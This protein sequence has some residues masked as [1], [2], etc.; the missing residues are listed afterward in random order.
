M[1]SRKE[2]LKFIKDHP[3]VGG[4]IAA[5][6]LLITGVMCTGT[7][8]ALELGIDVF[9][10][11]TG[12]ITPG[13]L[14]PGTAL[15]DQNPSDNEPKAKPGCKIVR[16]KETPVQLMARSGEQIYPGKQ[17]V[18]EYTAFGHGGGRDV[19]PAG[20]LDD[21]DR[22]SRVIWAG[23]QFCPRNPVQLNFDNKNATA[24]ESTNEGCI[25]VNADDTIWG[26]VFNNSAH[27]GIKD[28]IVVKRIGPGSDGTTTKNK[29]DELDIMRPDI[30]VG[31]LVCLP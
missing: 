3:K 18:I 27:D 14:F 31:D 30:K 17:V 15:P 12:E 6:V 1:A 19:F 25:T 26:I 29:M 21:L 16:D 5:T 10:P 28:D 24:I 13:P 22:I 7:M 2:G 9:A 20:S 23:D 11:T 4:G 8:R